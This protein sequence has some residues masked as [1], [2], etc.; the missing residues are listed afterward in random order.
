MEDAELFE[1]LK[2][3]ALDSAWSA[4]ARRGYPNQF[5]EGLRVF[6]PDLKIAVR[7]TTVRCLPVRPDLQQQ[8]REQGPPLN[9][10]SVEEADAGDILVIDAGG[11]TGGGF[12]GDI[13]AARLVAR[14][15]V[16]IVADGAIRDLEEIRRMPLGLYLKGAHAAGSGRRIM[17]VE[18]N[19]TV[20]CGNVTVVPGDVLYGDCEGVLVI[21]AALAV[22]VLAEAEATD[23]KELFLRAK[24]EAGESIYGIYPPSPETLRE[25]ENYKNAQRN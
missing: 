23:H 7:A 9:A 8:I 11:E 19:V 14:G 25:Y 3:V 17:P 20:R 16:G 18:R 21:P 1:R 4:L 24:L 13:I 2:N 22:E 5:C 6:R 12:L 15:G 10:Q